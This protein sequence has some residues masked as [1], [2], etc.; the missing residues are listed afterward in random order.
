MAFVLYSEAALV[1]KTTAFKFGLSLK[2]CSHKD[3]HLNVLRV[4]LSPK[5]DNNEILWKILFDY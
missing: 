2:G 4:G 3:V 1:K 5:E